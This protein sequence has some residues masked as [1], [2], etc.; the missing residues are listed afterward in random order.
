MHSHDD[1]PA[2]KL[3]SMNKCLSFV[4][5]ST[6]RSLLPLSLPLFLHN[7]FR[8]TPRRAAS[9]NATSS[10]VWISVTPR[11]RER[12]RERE[13]DRGKRLL[14][15][16]NYTNYCHRER[17]EG[18]TDGRTDAVG[19]ACFHATS[20]SLAFVPAKT[21]SQKCVLSFGK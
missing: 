20:D 16:F 21:E 19:L 6:P 5:R 7:R 3:K 11:G 13:G 8:A 18:R 9:S 12:G 15:G 17:T 14:R 10:S 2:L 1:V 4:P